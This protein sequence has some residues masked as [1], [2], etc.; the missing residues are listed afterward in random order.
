MKKD[1]ELKLYVLAPSETIAISEDDITPGASSETHSKLGNFFKRK[2][3]ETIVLEGEKAAEAEKQWGQCIRSAI[4]LL[5]Q[6]AAHP[7]KGW[8]AEE[9]EIGLSLD[10]KGQLA[11]VAEAHVEASIKVVYKRE[12]AKS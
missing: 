3:A 11:F 2:V 9:V 5:G 10:A 4:A 7:V 6:V 1:Q 12:P 8:N